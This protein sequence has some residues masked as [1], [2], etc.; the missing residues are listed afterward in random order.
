MILDFQ[1][2]LTLNFIVNVINFVAMAL[3]WKRYGER[4]AGVSF[5]THAMA[6]HVVGI[7]L[8]V[9]RGS[10]PLLI[11]SV[12]ANAFLMSSTILMFAGFQRFTGTVVRQTQ[13]YIAFV[14][15]VL[16]LY[17]YSTYE[18][19]IE[20]RNICGAALIIFIDAQTCRL[21]FWKV[22]ARMRQITFY[23]GVVMACYV[24]ASMVRIVILLSFPRESAV[25]WSGLADSVS[26][27]SY[28]ALH[29]CMIFA[30]FLTIVR[31]LMDDVSANEAKFVTAF[32][33]APYG[34]VIAR[35]GDLGVVEVNKGFCEIFGYSREEALGRP[36][37]ELLGVP[38][39]CDMPLG[40]APFRGMGRGEKSELCTTRR[41]GEPLI[42]EIMSEEVAING[43]RYVLATINDITKESRLKKQL[44]ELA[45]RDSLTGLP[46]RRFFYEQFS[47]ATL[48]AQRHRTRLAVMSLDLDQFK[49]VNDGLGHAA[50]DAVLIEAACR[51]SGCLR[52]IDLVARFGGD[53][54][55]VLLTDVSE[56]ED[57]VHVA[58]KIIRRFREPFEVQ[59][60]RLTTTASLGIALYP[61]HGQSLEELLNQSD[62]AL[63]KTKQS[64]RDGYHIADPI[65]G[66]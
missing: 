5:W 17:Y 6:V 64:G 61:E 15:Y 40:G 33:L 36:V 38:D 19:R 37:M 63:Y 34:L 48:Q 26:V 9:F 50:G 2:L 49:A 51:L 55:V 32:H 41:H 42:G 8:I 52:K 66:T 62:A 56:V 46:N 60:R 18:P 28:I 24:V 14:L 39:A 35:H 1:T 10:L 59:G 65:P 21:L 57:C 27:T 25:L 4:Y 11:S 20:Y 22:S 23:A 12:L 45:T 53:E 16:L 3:L 7:G 54:F 31:R 47:L 43:E 30:L 13:N 58:Q 44:E 29:I